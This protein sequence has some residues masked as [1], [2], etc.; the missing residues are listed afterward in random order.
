MAVVNWYWT[1]A[2]S[3]VLWWCRVTMK[4]WWVWTGLV[5]SLQKLI[6]VFLLMTYL[7]IYP[8]GERETLW[9][10]IALDVASTTLSDASMLHSY[11]VAK[12][13]IYNVLGLEFSHMF[14]ITSQNEQFSLMIKVIHVLLLHDESD[15]SV[16]V[17]CSLCI[18]CSFDTFSDFTHLQS[19][20]FHQVL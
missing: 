20:H 2:K 13:Y 3:K 17:T 14:V 6:T 11:A 7:N 5:E 10:H 12:D 15:T 8:W 16:A 4:V 9:Q 1:K 18:S 19:H